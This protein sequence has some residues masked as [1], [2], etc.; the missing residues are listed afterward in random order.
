LS[1]LKSEQN[2]LSLIYKLI[3]TFIL[4]YY[5][6]KTTVYLYLYRIV[7]NNNNNNNNNI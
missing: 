5:S 7:N 2:H 4:I 6:I 1:R 3:I